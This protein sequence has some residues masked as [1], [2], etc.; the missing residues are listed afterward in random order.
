MNDFTVTFVGDDGEARD[1]HWT[2][3][4]RADHARTA[5]DLAEEIHLVETERTSDFLAQIVP[6]APIDG[7]WEWNDRRGTDH[8]A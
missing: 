2:Y 3:V 4:V 1:S 6:G 5:L 8:E 7:V